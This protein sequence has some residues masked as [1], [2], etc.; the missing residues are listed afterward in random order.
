MSN[1]SFCHY[2][3]KKPSAAEASERVYMRER[4]NDNGYHPLN[5]LL[6]RDDI[7]HLPLNMTFENIAVKGEIAQNKQ[8]HLLLQYFQ[9]FININLLDC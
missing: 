4:V 8:F 3:F 9:L 2:V 1:F 5:P 7:W 6:H